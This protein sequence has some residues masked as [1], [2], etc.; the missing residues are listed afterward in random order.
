MNTETPDDGA[1]TPSSDGGTSETMDDIADEAAEL[2]GSYIKDMTT[3][4]KSSLDSIQAGTYKVED[5][6]ADG[7]SMWTL[8]MSGLGKALDLGTRTAKAYAKKTT[9]ET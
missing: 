5:A 8:Y 7:I 2:V 4:Y 1:E 3:T 9:D 6:W